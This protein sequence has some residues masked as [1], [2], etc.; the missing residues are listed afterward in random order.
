MEQYNSIKKKYPSAILFFRMGDFYEMFDDDAKIGS[1]VLGITLTAR[2]SGEDAVP[3]AGF[4]YHSLE[5][6]LS[7]MLRAGH[8]VAICEQVEDRAIILFAW[9]VFPGLQVEFDVSQ[10][11]VVY[12]VIAFFEEGIVGAG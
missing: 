11:R 1:D 9:R 8:K 12:L 2:S 5:T 6:Y 3:L 4:P 10:R 7:K